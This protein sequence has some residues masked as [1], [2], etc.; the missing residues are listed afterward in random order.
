MSGMSTTTA[1][2]INIMKNGSDPSL[3]KDDELP[4]W[5]W[6]LSKPGKTLSDLR[7]IAEQTKLE[8]M[9][10][11]DVSYVGFN[12]GLTWHTYSTF[13]RRVIFGTY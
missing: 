9:E 11:S 7:K 12:F 8:D 3:K 6:G 1:T 4:S 10:L 5:L 13:W 2:G